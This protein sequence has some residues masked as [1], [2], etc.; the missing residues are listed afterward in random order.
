VDYEDSYAIDVCFGDEVLE[1]S[2]ELLA[3]LA[4]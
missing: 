3:D 2:L 1:R 4:G